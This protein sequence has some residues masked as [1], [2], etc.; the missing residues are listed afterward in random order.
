V[1]GTCNCAENY[2]AAAGKLLGTS[3]DL[4]LVPQKE[5]VDG[6]QTRPSVVT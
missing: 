3:T 2:W 6:S 4:R 1:R 5:H